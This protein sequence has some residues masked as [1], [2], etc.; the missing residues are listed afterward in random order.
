MR[1]SPLVKLTR[2]NT[3][4]VF[5]DD[6]LGAEDHDGRHFD[7]MVRW[8]LEHEAMVYLAGDHIENSIVSGKEIGEKL[9][10]QRTWP[11]AQALEF[12]DKIK[13][14]VVKGRVAGSL[15]GNHEARSRRESLLDICELLA[16]LMGY[17]YDHVGGTV[18]FQAGTQVYTTAIHHG[19]S[20][21][22]NTWLELDKMLRLYPHAELV[23]L[24]HNHDLNARPVNHI[25]VDARGME[26]VSRRWQVRSGSCLGYAEYARQLCLSPSTL[27]HPVIRFGRERHEIDVDTRTLAAV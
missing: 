15:R 3:L 27:G 17:R 25:T 22:G 24:G 10:E 9:L 23:S 6:H 14:L 4:V 26:H 2:T 18:R 7:E 12:A 5:S 21:A 20:G 19:R 1:P 11:T 16:G 13:P 8:C